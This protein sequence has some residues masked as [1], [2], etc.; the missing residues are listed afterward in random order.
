[1]KHLFTTVWY[2]LCLL[3]IGSTLYF[4]NIRNAEVSD[5]SQPDKSS[6]TRP[7][8]VYI[9]VAFSASGLGNMMFQ[10]ASLYGIAKRTR[11]IPVVYHRVPLRDYFRLSAN[12]SALIRPG[13]TWAKMVEFHASRYD[14]VTVNVAEHSNTDVELVGYFQSWMYFREAFHAVRNEFQFSANVSSRVETL[15]RAVGIRL[16]DDGKRRSSET[17]VTPIGI[18]VRRGDILSEEFDK[19]GY[20]VPDA[21]YIERAMRYFECN[22][23]AKKPH[24]LVVSND[25]DW[26]VNNIRTRRRLVTFSRGNDAITDMALL[27]SCDH[28]VMTVGTFGWWAAWLSGGQVVYYKNFPRNGSSLERSFSPTKVDY[29]LPNWIG[30]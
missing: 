6:R 20:A 11:R 4:F 28:V 15:L 12:V 18:H 27:A 2:P 29:F 9:S 5:P 14:Q 30:M 3:C 17:N 13:E 25:V 23:T 16:S 24:F 1:M 19:F 7:Q 8:P 10:Y 22:R 26:C 21:A